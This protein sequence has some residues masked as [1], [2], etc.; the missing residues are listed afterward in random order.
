MIQT[1]ARLIADR[2]DRS[3]PLRLAFD[4]WCNIDWPALT[5]ALGNEAAASGLRLT[6]RPIATVF[7]SRGT[8]AAALHACR[9]SSG[10]STS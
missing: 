8:I 5:A 2:N 6:C 4:G 1:L 3:R 9:Y 10:T 7:R